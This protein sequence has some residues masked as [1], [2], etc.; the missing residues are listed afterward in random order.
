M[1]HEIENILIETDRFILKKISLE[2]VNINYLSWFQDPIIKKE[3]SAQYSIN[4]LLKL[5]KYVKEKLFKQ[6]KR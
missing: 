5:K 6:P 2:D 4:D 3:I 1:L